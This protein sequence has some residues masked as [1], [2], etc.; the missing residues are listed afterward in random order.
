MVSTLP[1]S[2]TTPSPG[3]EVANARVKAWRRAAR[4]AKG[5]NAPFRTIFAATWVEET[6]Q[7]PH[8]EIAWS[9]STQSSE[10]EPDWVCKEPMPPQ[11]PKGNECLKSGPSPRAVAPE[12][13][14]VDRGL[15]P[16]MA[17]SKLGV[18]ETMDLL[19][20]V[21]G[22]GDEDPELSALSAALQTKLGLSDLRKPPPTMSPGVEILTRDL[23]SLRG[24]R[25]S[26]MDTCPSPFH[27]R[28]R[29]V[30]LCTVGDTTEAEMKRYG[31]VALAPLATTHAS[32]PSGGT[33]DPGVPGRGTKAIAAANLQME[34]L[35]F[36][37][38]NLPE[39]AEE[40]SEFCSSRVSN[41]LM[42]RPI[43]RL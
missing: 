23:K 32:P 38:K 42:S 3:V 17:A 39:W 28:V 22:A 24:I 8:G 35:K 26:P 40:F 30:P 27:P 1:P 43:A 16:R 15:P 20:R 37:P 25:S 33:G 14:C 5:K 18:D 36:A 21:L 34:L 13:T 2:E 41:M 9:A 12:S 11:E 6:F 19:S 29:T 4:E 10:C 7:I 31:Q